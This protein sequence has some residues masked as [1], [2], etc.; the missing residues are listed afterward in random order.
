MY[1]DTV[2]LFCRYESR[3]GDAWYPT[4]LRNVHINMDKSAIMAKY[5][6][7][8]RDSAILNVRYTP[9][10]ASAIAGLAVAGIS[11]SGNSSRKTAKIMID[12]KEYFPPKQWDRQTND[13]LPSSLTFTDGDKFDFFWV[14]EWPDDAPISDDNYTDGFYNYM[15]RLYDHVF[16]ITSVGGPYG[17]IPHFEIMGA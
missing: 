12:V 17:V 6:A 15:N 9:I 2:T 10:T 7:E 3:L 5:G 1:N 8:S 16:A 13:Q 11:I 4:V 14:G